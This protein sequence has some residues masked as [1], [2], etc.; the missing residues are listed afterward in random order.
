M[1]CRASSALGLKRI[2]SFLLQYVFDSCVA[3]CH[4]FFEEKKITP[5]WILVGLYPG[6]TPWA[7]VCR[8]FSALDS[9]L[10]FNFLLQYVV[11]SQEG[12]LS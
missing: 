6:L 5:N 11:N 4:D 10:N 9:K 12:I 8:A 2:F 7:M 3:I 1:F